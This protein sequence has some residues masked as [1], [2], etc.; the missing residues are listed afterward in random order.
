MRGNIVCGGPAG[1]GPNFIAN[2]IS[3]G[4]F[5]KGFYIFSSREYESRIRGGHNY[6]IIT[7][8]D[9]PLYS[10]SVPIDILIALDDVSETIH[11]SNL[12]KNSIIIKAEKKNVFAVGSAFKLLDMDFSILESELKGKSNYDENIIEAKK[13]YGAENRTFSLPKMKKINNLYL[14]TGNDGI[15]FGASHSDLDFYY[16]YPMTP[17]TGVLFKL[18]QEEHSSKHVT[19]QLE[20]EIAVINAAIGSAITGKKAMIGTSGGGFDLMTEALSLAGGADI[21]LVMYLA[22]RPGPA[23]GAPTYTSQGD[24]NIARHAGHGEFVRVVSAPGDPKEC[25]DITSESFYLSQKYLLPAI[26]LSDKH[27]ADS[28][29]SLIEK[30]SLVKSQNTIKWPARFTSYESDKNKIADNSEKI[31]IQSIQKRKEKYLKL[32]KEILSMKSYAIY[33]KKDSK[34][35][36]IGWGS[37]KGAILDSIKDLDC[38]FIQIIYLEPFSRKIKEELEKA[39]NLILVENNATSILSSLIAEKTGILIE[40]KNKIT[41]YDG[42]PFFYEDLL[43]EI[44]RRLK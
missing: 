11:K 6:N 12:K 35:L 5:E 33:G 30:S 23:T 26:I 32:E 29:Y 13:G 4:L 36:V 44:K 8:S 21:P 1:Q 9:S 7:F 18:A 2:I 15:S 42:R 19:V 24:L 37:T 34:N 3:K 39:N 38:K 40:D 28:T 17:A 41:K 25:A 20:S 16:A 22:Q 10:N 14:W 31:I 27:L 43:S